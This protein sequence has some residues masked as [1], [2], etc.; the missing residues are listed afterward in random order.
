MALIINCD[1]CDRELTEK[2][3][4]LLSPP[5]EI[6]GSEAVQKYHICVRCWEWLIKFTVDKRKKKK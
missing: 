6:D 2:G 4:I 5:K 3:A 1:R